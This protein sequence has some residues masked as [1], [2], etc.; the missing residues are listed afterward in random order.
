MAAMRRDC[1]VG[2]VSDSV[3]SEGHAIRS[4]MT[5]GV[6]VDTGCRLLVGA[7]GRR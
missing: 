2:L 5:G 6:R 3:V 4:R 7:I 1:S